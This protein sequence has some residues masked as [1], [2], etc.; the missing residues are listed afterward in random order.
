M[1]DNYYINFWVDRIGKPK[2]LVLISKTL[3]NIKF[4]SGIDED[5]YLLIYF[6]IFYLAVALKC[7][8]L[9]IPQIA[10]FIDLST[11]PSTSDTFKIS[12]IFEEQKNVI[13][14]LTKYITE[15]LMSYEKKYSS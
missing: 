10:F 14:D 12:Q 4:P 15:D 11:N 8:G 2:F 1:E 3:I 13:P 7:C 6:H 5:E 9:T